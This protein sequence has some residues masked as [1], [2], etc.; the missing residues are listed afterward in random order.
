MELREMKKMLVGQ[1]SIT[2]PVMPCHESCRSG[3]CPCPTVQCHVP[4]PMSYAKLNGVLFCGA[5]APVPQP[6]A[7]VACFRALVTTGG[8][9][10]PAATERHRTPSDAIARWGQHWRR[11]PRGM[12]IA[13]DR[14]HSRL[15]IWQARRLRLTFRQR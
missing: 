3:P 13:I 2:P 7:A 5:S 6:D 10:P 14:R 9:A 12:V 8:Q 11:L 4:P 15:H 1:S